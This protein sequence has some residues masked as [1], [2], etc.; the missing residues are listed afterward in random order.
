MKAA[1]W[2]RT[3]LPVVLASVAA[4]PAAAG[5]R[6]RLPER[7]GPRPAA[8]RSPGFFVEAIPGPDG[9]PPA[10]LVRGRDLSGRLRADGIDLALPAP[11]GALARAGFTF[12]GA[13]P[14]GAI[15]AAR[16]LPGRSHF[17]LGSDPSRWT[18]GVPHFAEASRGDLWPGTSVRWH[19][20]DGRIE[21]DLRLAPGADASRAAFAVDGV[22]EAR[23]DAEGRLEAAAAGG[24]LL[25]SRP[26]AWQEAPEG[27][28]PVAARY[29]ARADGSFGFSLGA[30]DPHLPTVID[31]VL[32]FR[33]V[34]SANGNF[35]LNTV[36][37]VAVGADGSVF[38]SGLSNNAGVATAGVFQ[39]AKSGSQDATVARFAPDGTLAWV[40]YLGGS[41][42]DGAYTVAAGADGTATVCGFTQSANFPLK[43]ALKGT[44]G[45]TQDYFVARLAAD[46]ASLA[47]STYF[48]GSGADSSGFGAS[49]DAL[50]LDAAGDVWLAGTTASA[51]LPVPGGFQT[52]LAGGNDAF[53]AGIASDGQSVLFGTYLGGALNDWTEGLALAPD[54]TVALSGG[55]GSSDF[56]R[57]GG[58]AGPG[59][60]SGNWTFG[61]AA[62]VATDGTGI[63][64][65]TY[66][67]G[68]VAFSGGSVALDADGALFVAGST[69]SAN[70]PT[71]PGTVQEEFAGT[72]DAF[73]MKIRPDGSAVEWSTLLGSPAAESGLGVAVDAGG[74]PYLCGSTGDIERFPLANPLPE[75]GGLGGYGFL[76]KFAP[77]GSRLLYSTGILGVQANDV[78]VDAPGTAFLSSYGEAVAVSFRIP[79]APS[80]L[81]VQTAPGGALALSWTDAGADEDGFEI[82]RRE[83]GGTWATLAAT[84]P[85]ASTFLDAGLAPGVAF[86]YRVR[87]VNGAGPS[88]FS[89]PASGA[90]EGTVTLVATKGRLVNLLVPGRDRLSAAGTLAFGPGSPDGMVDPT[91]DE[92]I[93]RAGPADTPLVLAVPAGD[94]GWTIRGRRVAWRSPEGETPRWQVMLDPDAG[95][96]RVSVARAD[97]PAPP[98]GTVRIVLF[99]GDDAG[100]GTSD[101]TRTRPGVF[102][103]R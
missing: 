10:L 87:A 23:I 68:Y 98:D 46:G 96:F 6:G 19:G 3:L 32:E 34:A 99:A 75:S 42:S 73:L 43:D 37:G 40:T 74:S 62:R 17:L 47:W 55:T 50:A 65:S 53:L 30:L 36:S 13:S 56:P 59:V 24:T 85:G 78:A 60:A 49:P 1:S 83:P 4:V 70:F 27:R 97:F 22:A 89:A 44:L 103:L 25:L 82:Q 80:G 8:A 81:A 7:S 101:W 84:G 95:R 2:R 16:P 67:G 18:R 92:V 93:V 57:V 31:P 90:I 20:R 39:A 61:W 71:T 21:F 15:R 72:Q 66:L 79:D 9:G 102:V 88:A 77:D 45:G 91:T 35:Y 54:G 41:S 48:G 33:T 52:V 26:V 14:G 100:S 94:P 5:I 63:R 76:A 38:C 12:R 28:R 58:F 51:D 86:E 11:D 69:I 64:F 29:E